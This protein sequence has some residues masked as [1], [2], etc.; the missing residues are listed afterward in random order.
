MKNNQ[1]QDYSKAINEIARFIRDADSII[2]AAGAGMGLETQN[3]ASPK[4][5]IENS[6]RAWSFYG[7]RLNMYNQTVPHLG[8][9]LL[10]K[11]AMRKPNGYA[12]FTSNIDGQFEKAG[13]DADHVTECL[14][15][16]SWLQC[17]TPCT[18]DIWPATDFSILEN[19]ATKT[20][21]PKCPHCGALARP[22][23]LLSNDTTWVN[24]RTQLQEDFLVELLERMKSPVIIEIGAGIGPVRHFSH[25]MRCEKPS[26]PFIRI[27]PHSSQTG[28]GAH[29][30]GLPMGALDAL[31]A[32][33]ALNLI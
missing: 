21:L 19:Y 30:V 8:F 5:F 2:I 18:D 29:C 32:I 24:K 7:Q 6:V 31:T 4:A 13:F 27:N 10:K 11:W 14:G 16:I 22:N 3:I 20:E 33:D 25:E 12:V 1:K 17:I 9:Q 23:V 26:S 28:S 15:R